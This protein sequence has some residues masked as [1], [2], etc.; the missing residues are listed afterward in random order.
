[1]YGRLFHILGGNLKGRPFFKMGGIENILVTIVFAAW[2]KKKKIIIY[3]GL[4][5]PHFALESLASMDR[6]KKEI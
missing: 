3:Q 6:C 5:S 1:M 2:I 4:S